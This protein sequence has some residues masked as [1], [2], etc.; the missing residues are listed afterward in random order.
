MGVALPADAEERLAELAG[1]VM[2]DKSP[3]T[4]FCEFLASMVPVSFHDSIVSGLDAIAALV[5]APANWYQRQKYEQQLKT[6]LNEV[7]PEEDYGDSSY[8]E[9]VRSQELPTVELPSSYYDD[10]DDDD[11]GGS[12]SPS[13]TEEFRETI[14]DWF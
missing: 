7:S 10:D 11:D 14:P 5:D 8:T 12:T 6:Y 1:M 2:Q 9:W 4:E 13:S 3:L